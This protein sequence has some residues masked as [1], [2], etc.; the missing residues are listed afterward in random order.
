M[1]ACSAAARST[2]HAHRLLVTCRTVEPSCGG[3]LVVRVLLALQVSIGVQTARRT[4]GLHSRCG[5]LAFM[6]C[7]GVNPTASLAGSATLGLS[8]RIAAPCAQQRHSW[9][10][11][12]T[13]CGSYTDGKQTGQ[14]PPFRIT[15]GSKRPLSLRLVSWTDRSCAGPLQ[16]ARGARTSFSH[17]VRLQ[18]TTLCRVDPAVHR[19]GKCC[20]AFC[21]H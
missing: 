21:E 19:L 17:V 5:A 11:L 3:H 16:G 2:C 6:R 18:V 8:R 10:E 13:H 9:P 15:G 1:A 20:S 7:R 12:Y 4:L 14:P